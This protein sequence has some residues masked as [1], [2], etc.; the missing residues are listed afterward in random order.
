MVFTEGG[1]GGTGKSEI[2]N[3]LIPWYQDQDIEP[4]L[5]DFD[6]ENANKSGLQN[7]YPEARKLDVHAPGALDE[8]F[9]V[10]DRDDV[11]VVVADLGAG[12]GKATFDWFNATFEV[13]QELDLDFTAIGVT[14]NEPGAVQSILK[15]AH[16][17]QDQVSYL[18]VLNELSES[19]SA[20]EYWHDEPSVDAFLKAFE[21]SVMTMKARVPEFQAELRNQCATLQQVIDR[22]VTEPFLREMKNVARARRAQRQVFEGFD[23]AAE[24]LLP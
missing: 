6:L 5:L 19:N 20:F 11:D 2:I 24:I 17:L 15:W 1:K 4:M 16:E 13:A 14:N 12:A 7:F 21:P 18:I 9:G 3:A 8:F 23:R 10:C 22:A